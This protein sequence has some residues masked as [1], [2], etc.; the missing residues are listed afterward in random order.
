MVREIAARAH[1]TPDQ[2]SIE[3]GAAVRAT[4]PIDSSASAD[5]GD[6]IQ[7]PIEDTEGG[8]RADKHS[9]ALNQEQFSLRDLRGISM[10]QPN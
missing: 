2:R 10:V 4:E 8:E 6:V 5:S 7:G 3:V 9:N 1:R